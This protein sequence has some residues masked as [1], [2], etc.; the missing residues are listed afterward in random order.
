MS[1]ASQQRAAHGQPQA[2]PGSAMANHGTG[3]AAASF[4]TRQEMD[5]IFHGGEQDGCC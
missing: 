5:L 1:E 3:V 4:R 2:A